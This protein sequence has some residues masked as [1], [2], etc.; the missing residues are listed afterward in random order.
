LLDPPSHRLNQFE[1]ERAREAPGY[2]VL[3]LGEVAPVGIEAIGPDLRAGPGV[4]QLDIDLHLVADPAHASS[5][6]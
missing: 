5:S 2:L 3:R 4:D 1:I 6:A